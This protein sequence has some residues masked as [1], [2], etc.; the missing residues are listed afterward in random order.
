MNLLTPE[1][2]VFLFTLTFSY[3]LKTIKKLD[4]EFG[5]DSHI[6]KTLAKFDNEK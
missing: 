5:T 1:N 3:T 2:F 4:P 6:E